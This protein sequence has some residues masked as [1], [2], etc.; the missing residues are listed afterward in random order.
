MCSL[1]RC[2]AEAR[3]ARAGDAGHAAKP[4][5]NKGDLLRQMLSKHTCSDYW[6]MDPQSELRET[7]TRGGALSCII[8]DSMIMPNS[9]SHL[10]VTHRQKLLGYAAGPYGRGFFDG[11][12]GR[13]KKWLMSG[14]AVTFAYPVRVA[15][16]PAEGFKASSWEDHAFYQRLHPGNTCIPTPTIDEFAEA[17]FDMTGEE[18]IRCQ[19]SHLTQRGRTWFAV[20]LQLWAQENGVQLV[21]CVGWNAGGQCKKNLVTSEINEEY[22]SQRRLVEDIRRQW[23]SG[24]SESTIGA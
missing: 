21:L 19:G 10:R 14:A 7:E 22:A 17:Y 4:M 6:E 1:L 20:A 15:Y 2:V 12:F 9:C 18:M 3:K 13:F 16:V 24:S 23:H 5:R 8:I 11:A